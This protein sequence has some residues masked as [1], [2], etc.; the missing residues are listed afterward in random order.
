MADEQQEMREDQKLP[1][2]PETLSEL[3]DSDDE[4]S[5]TW[6]S[7]VNGELLGGSWFKKYVFFIIFVI[8]LTILYVSNRYA[9][10]RELLEQTR[11]TETLTDRR[12]KALTASSLLKEQTRRS[13]LMDMLVD[14][15]LEAPTTPIYKIQMDAEDAPI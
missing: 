5:L 15:T 6:R 10:Q 14:T 8:V 2:R 13:Q 9:C 12:Y 7:F 11:L 1:K 4:S 3:L